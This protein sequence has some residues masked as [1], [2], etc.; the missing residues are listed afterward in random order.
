LYWLALIYLLVW[1]LLNYSV[2]FFLIHLDFLNP[3]ITF[4]PYC[5]AA[6]IEFFITTSNL[7]DPPGKWSSMLVL[8][9]IRSLCMTLIL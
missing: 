6:A 8:C 2:I 7:S 1:S 9:T 3:P 5:T 4:L